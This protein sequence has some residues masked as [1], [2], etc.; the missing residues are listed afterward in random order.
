MPEEALQ[1]S[2]LPAHLNIKPISLLKDFFQAQ[3]GS[4]AGTVCSCVRACN[5][6]TCAHTACLY[7]R[8]Q[9]GDTVSDGR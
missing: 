2:K 9:R 8:L 1:L 5:T 4:S 6:C 3:N 7:T